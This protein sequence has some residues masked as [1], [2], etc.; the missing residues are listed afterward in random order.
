M[1]KLHSIGAL[2]HGAQSLAAAA[3]GLL[4]CAALSAPTVYP[5]G[6]TIYDSERAWNGYTVFI[7]PDDTGGVLIDMNG[8]TVKTWPEFDGLA[9]GP[10]RIL[11]GGHAM[12]GVGR[13]LPHQEARSV[14][15]LDWDGNVV[16]EFDRLERVESD[17]GEAWVARQHHDWQRAGFPAG[18]YSPEADPRVTSG[19]TLVLAHRNVTN[20]AVASRPLED[21]YL[22][23]VS[24][25]G[26]IGWTW[27]ASD[28]VGDFGFSAEARDVIQGAPGYSDA[29]GSF[30]WLHINSA[31][32]L[33]PNRWHDGG[34]ERF[35]PDNV[36]ISARNANIVAIIGRSG[37]VV[38]Q[39]GPDYTSEAERAIGQIIGQH[40]PHM[41]PKG[42]PGAGNV[43]IFDNG[44]SAG[45]GHANPAAPNGVSAVR[46]GYSR[47][48]EIDPVTLEKV[49]EYAVPGQENYR[50]FSH[51]VSSAQR[52]ANGNTMITEGADG[53]LFEVTRDG[54]I[55][56]EYVSPYFSEQ[57]G[58]TNRVYRAYRLPYDWVPQLPRPVERD[59]VPPAVSDF[60]VP[61][62]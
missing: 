25:D 17:S 38:W 19:G 1:N 54:D 52:L 45:Y 13:R 55:V 40:H 53:R 41:I 36:I 20:P 7:A 26:E 30:D 14:R 28:H 39:L 9:G 42:L 22:A 59:V 23:E 62:E 33:G 50:F 58:R 15:Q 31:T 46:R 47:V 24:W 6:T 49:W 12:G 61:A 2:R 32:Y 35:A 21:D 48:V 10:V 57:P 27:L 51:Y 3:A 16:W 37:D 18:Y 44:G 29:R 60:R 11:P 34:D 4:A 43:L 5:T 56:W 8:E